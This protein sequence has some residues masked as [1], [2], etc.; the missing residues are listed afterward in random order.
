MGA[1]LSVAQYKSVYQQATTM[2]TQVMNN[3]ITKADTS[4]Y[5]NQ[6]ITIVN[7]AT[8]TPNGTVVQGV[9]KCNLNVANV[10]K[11]TITALYTLKNEMN[12]QTSN[13]LVTQLTQAIT[14]SVHQA[15]SSINMGQINTSVDQKDIQTQIQTKIQNQLV[16]TVNQTFGTTVV[17]NQGI[18]FVN[19]GIVDAGPDGNCNF[20][21][22][23]TLDLFVQLLLNNTADTLV[24]NYASLQNQITATTT[25][26]QSNAGLSL[27][28]LLGFGSIGGIFVIVLIIAAVGGVGFMI[29]KNKKDSSGGGGGGGMLGKLGKK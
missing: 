27:A 1:N 26:D 4:A 7:G 29:I 8:T 24:S 16:N 18:T 19:Y 17:T 15:N 2:T 20:T 23:F 11:S 6:T 9:M 5:T 28:G 3:Y 12:T 10:G 14:D 13:Q 22:Q 21:N 25:T